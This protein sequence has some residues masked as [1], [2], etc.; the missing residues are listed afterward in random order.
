VISATILVKTI[1]VKRR[2]EKCDERSRIVAGIYFNTLVS[3]CRGRFGS[4]QW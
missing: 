2:H 1:Q 3:L 4:I